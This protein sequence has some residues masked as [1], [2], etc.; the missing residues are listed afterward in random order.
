M[1]C[2]VL[3]KV[4]TDVKGHRRKVLKYMDPP[5]PKRKRRKGKT[6]KKRAPPRKPHKKLQE[7]QNLIKK[8]YP[9]LKTHHYRR[10]CP[11][12]RSKHVRPENL[13]VLIFKLF[14]IW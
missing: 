14:S 9:L 1:V 5:K 3:R 12:D 13:P 8:L 11:S 10:S 2:N 4:W 7:H 6:K